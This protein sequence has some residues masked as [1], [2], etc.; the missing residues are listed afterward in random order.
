MQMF[1][2]RFSNYIQLTVK[3]MYFWR[4]PLTPPTYYILVDGSVPFLS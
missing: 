2:L 4:P 1:M 3:Y